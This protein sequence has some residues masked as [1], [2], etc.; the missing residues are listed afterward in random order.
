MTTE[1]IIEM[2]QTAQSN[3]VGH[4][5]PT[6][7]VHLA[8]ED[9]WCKPEREDKLYKNKMIAVWKHNEERGMI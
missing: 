3:V 8:S 6:S 4:V 1:W 9:C 2:H 5:I 7:G